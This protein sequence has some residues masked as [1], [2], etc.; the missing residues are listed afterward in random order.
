RRPE[1][2]YAGASELGQDLERHLAHEPVTARAATRR[3][4]IGR[5]ARRHAL[6]VALASAVTVLLIAGLIAVSL[7]SHQLARER[8]RAL[9]SAQ[10]SER[11]ADA[12]AGMIRLSDAS[13]PIDQLFTVG[14]RLEQYRD[15]VDT[16]LAADPRLQARLF[17]I[18]GEA[19]Q[20]LRYWSQARDAFQRALALHRRS[21]SDD[22][23]RMRQLELSLAEAEAFA[24][25][26]PGALARLNRM[27]A[28]ARES[29][30]AKALADV[31][32]QS[33]D[34]RT[35]H[36]QQGSAQFAAGIDDL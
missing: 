25:A 27:L 12:L 1:R 24:D 6:P 34:I 4:R 10:R 35:Y 21:G 18:L 3:Y 22:V 19:F 30:D 5:F 11:L 28:Q 2:R 9:A 17:A 20:N 29:N 8:D 32:Y 33:G 36:F 31:L 7:Q 26:L 14:E 23:D 13:G 15:H 16:E